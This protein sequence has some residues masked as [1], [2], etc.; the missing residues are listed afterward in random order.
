MVTPPKAT[1]T[2][3]VEEHKA[4]FAPNGHEIWIESAIEPVNGDFSLEAQQAVMNRMKQ[5]MQRL[6]LLGVKDVTF[7]E[8][9]SNSATATD[10]RPR[11]VLTSTDK[12][13]SVEAVS[14]A[15]LNDGF[16]LVN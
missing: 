7:K 15:L 4:N 11:V 5:L 13:L 12:N 10:G 9:G 14:K 16:A 2:V 3:R 8:Q 6:E 1:T